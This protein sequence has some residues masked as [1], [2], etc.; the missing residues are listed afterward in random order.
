MTNKELIASG[1]LE[2]YVAG[3]LPESRMKEIAEIATN[4][5]EV[6]SEIEQIEAI[7][8]RLAKEANPKNEQHFSEVLKKIIVDRVATDTKVRSLDTSEKSASKSPNFRNIVGWAAAILFLVFFGLQYQQNAK[9]DEEIINKEKELAAL[10]TRLNN[11]VAELSYKQ[12]VLS[13]VTSDQTKIIQLAGQQI[14]PKSAVKVFWDQENRQVVLDTKKLPKAPEGMVYQVWSL[15][16][17]PLQPTSI[18][19]LEGH[20]DQQNLFLLENANLSEGFGITLEPAGG[21][22]VP[23]LEKLYVLGVVAS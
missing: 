18:G 6:L 10:Q 11:Q 19:L 22:K 21:S 4:D 15:K 5:A 9:L 12:S 20:G 16:L 14:S 17:N 1:E 7:V 13:A 3:V 2:L 23:T 8:M